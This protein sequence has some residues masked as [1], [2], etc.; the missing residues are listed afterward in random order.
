MAVEG[1]GA[2][3]TQWGC[4]GTQMAAGQEGAGA[5]NSSLQGSTVRWE[6]TADNIPDL[7]ITL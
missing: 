2:P 4:A 7:A 3:I 6:E 1:P 5:P